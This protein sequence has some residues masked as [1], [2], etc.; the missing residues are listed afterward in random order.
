MIL[1][2]TSFIHDS[3]GTDLEKGAV[4][5]PHSEVKPSFLYSLS[6]TPFR[7]G[8]PLPKKNLGSAPVLAVQM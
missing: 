6:V 1:N 8:A 4:G 3:S 7:T 2:R 5:P